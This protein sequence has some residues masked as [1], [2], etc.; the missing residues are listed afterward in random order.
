MRRLNSGLAESRGSGIETE[1]A[2]EYRPLRSDAAAPLRQH[3]PEHRNRDKASKVMS[4]VSALCALLMLDLSF[5][6]SGLEN[7]LW[8]CR[9]HSIGHRRQTLNVLSYA[10]GI[11]ALALH[12]SR[13][14]HAPPIAA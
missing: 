7:S 3:L 9:A 13:Q 4:V 14:R 12:L 2:R 8:L 10:L 6:L 5:C 11:N 1:G